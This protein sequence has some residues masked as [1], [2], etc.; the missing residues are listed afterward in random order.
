MER[1]ACL[2]PSKG[3]EPGARSAP[4]ERSADPDCRGKED[5][6]ADGPGV[7]THLGERV[8]E[9]EVRSMS[10]TK[11]DL[12][13]YGFPARCLG[14]RARL[15]GSPRQGHSEECRRRLEEEMKNEPK[16]KVSKERENECLEKV[17]RKQDEM[18]KRR[19]E[20]QVDERNK[21]DSMQL[22]GETTAASGAGASSSTGPTDCSGLAERCG[23]EFR[24]AQVFPSVCCAGR[25]A[26]FEA[27]IGSRRGRSDPWLE[28]L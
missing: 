24:S 6:D 13:K 12:E 1:S 4:V 21:G 7:K 10:I 11:V 23:S 8:P 16:R 28:S 5:E 3:A 22:E 27:R 18:W 19:N 26:W 20:T 25:S 2:F 17:Q 15:E 9:P 14:C